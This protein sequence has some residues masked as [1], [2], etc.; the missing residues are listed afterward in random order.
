[1]ETKHLEILKTKVI[2][3]SVGK[4]WNVAKKEWRG[5]LKKLAAIEDNEECECTYTPLVF[6]Y[7][8][9][10]IKNGATMYPIGSKCIKHF[11]DDALDQDLTCLDGGTNKMTSGQY[12]GVPYQDIPRD[13]IDS[14]TVR[15]NQAPA[16]Q[17]LATWSDRTA[18]LRALREYEGS[19]PVP[20]LDATQELAAVVKGRC[21]VWWDPEESSV[22]VR[23]G[24]TVFTE[25]GPRAHEC[26]LRLAPTDYRRTVQDVDGIVRSWQEYA[27]R[28]DATPI[29]GIVV[30]NDLQGWC[31]LRALHVTRRSFFL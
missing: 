29:E 9:R 24:K 23:Y 12:K 14:E 7:E 13:Y 11:G 1:M 4:D 28:Q 30:G 10:N 25:A 31:L 5:V 22:V 2:R 6:L 21:Q 26:L 27:M 19:F 8:I 17:K 3:L 20:P 18:H 16:Y 15:N